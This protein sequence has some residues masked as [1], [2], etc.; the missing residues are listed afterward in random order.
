MLFAFF[1]GCLLMACAWRRSVMNTVIPRVLGLLLL[2]CLVCTDRQIWCR[3]STAL[4]LGSK[5][6]QPLCGAAVVHG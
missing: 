3:A 4:V 5:V 6:S 1:V 2:T